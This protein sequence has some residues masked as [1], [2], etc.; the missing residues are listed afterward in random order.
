M[1]TI[2]HQPGTAEPWSAQ[3]SSQL[4]GI[5]EWGHGYFTTSNRGTIAVCP[6][7]DSAHQLDLFELVEGLRLR[8]IHTPVLLRFSDLLNSRIKE[9]K[10]AFQAAIDENEYTGG[11]ACVYP[12]K[13]NQQCS[14]CEE[15]RDF[16]GPLGF[17]LEAGSKPELLAVLGL[18]EGRPDMPIICNGFKDTEYVET[19]VL[20]T[21]LGRRIIPV[22]EQAVELDR[23]ITQ[24]E[25]YQIHPKIGVRI[26]PSTRGS[27]RWQSSAGMRSK[28]GLQISEVLAAVEKLRTR[29][30]L[31]CLRLVHFHIGSQICDIRTLKNAVSE[32]AHT[33]AELRR[34]GAESLDMIDIGGGLGVDYDGSQ[35]SWASS[36][37]YSMRE[38]ASDI[39]Y[40]IKTA[41]DDAQQ[42]HPTIISESGRALAA[43]SSVLV[44]DVLGKT[45]FPSDP[46]LAWI[47]QTIAAEETNG[48]EVAQ[49]V[50]DL[51]NAYESFNGHEPLEIFHDAS[52]A[53]EEAITLFGMGYMSLPLRA[54]TER[55]FWAIGRRVIE[56][57][58][59]EPDSALSD[60]I[61]DL[62][63]TLSDIYFCNFSLFQ[64]LPDSWAIDQL[65][66]ICPI[67][68]LD[69]KPTRRAILADITCDSDGQISK[70]CSVEGQTSRT[71]I[72][73]HELR[74]DEPYYL[75]F[76]LV[77][78]YQ[79]VLGDLHN[80]FGDTH[81]VHVSL[82]PDGSWSIGEVVEGDTVREVLSYLQFQPADLKR[83]MRRDAERAVREGRMSVEESRALLSFYESGLEGYTY[84]E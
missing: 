8:G 60:Q 58:A 74:K 36:V 51:L 82:E 45:H 55:L 83:A 32:L 68:R 66:P 33:Y 78:A 57:A 29:N 28:F 27:G 31:D 23:I 30:M 20:A 44:V 17:G 6:D 35:S 38:Y 39:V 56:F 2:P 40:R 49:P 62:P 16:G 63:E 71:T 4:Y 1:T 37:N 59:A 11:Y 54:V 61:G 12:I 25:R 18:T 69:E 41:C 73:L 77:G 5:D 53:R 52:A 75:G 3:A 70:F 14:F 64:S 22:V 67:H 43:Y 80:L 24:A 9:L 50:I 21:K 34:L 84:L 47:R 7:R 81:A 42:P 13:V 76:F 79:E 19:V 26:K 65:F 72:E 10:D 48:Q 15:I 46:D